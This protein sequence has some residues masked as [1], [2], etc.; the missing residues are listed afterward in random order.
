MPEPGLEGLELSGS[1]C[2]IQPQQRLIVANLCAFAM[3]IVSVENLRDRRVS[4][5]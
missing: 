4:F 1:A 2:W 5:Q 3:V